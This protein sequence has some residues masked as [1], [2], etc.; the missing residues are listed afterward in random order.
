[1]N[2]EDVKS[3]ISTAD[4]ETLFSLERLIDA[5]FDQ[6]AQ[7]ERQVS[8]L[9]IKGEIDNTVNRLAWLKSGQFQRD[10]TRSAVLAGK[11]KPTEESTEPIVQPSRDAKQSARE[12]LNYHMGVNNNV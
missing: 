10:L 11:L 9:S 7:Q 6:L 5:R 4:S 1:M 3:F 2:F 12:K 8:L